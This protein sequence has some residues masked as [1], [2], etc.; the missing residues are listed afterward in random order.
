LFISSLTR[1][2]AE[3]FYKPLSVPLLK[4]K[5]Q[6]TQQQQKGQQQQQRLKLQ[7]NLPASLLIKSHLLL[8]LNAKDQPLCSEFAL[9][10]IFSL[11]LPHTLKRTKTRA[12]LRLFLASHLTSRLLSHQKLTRLPRGPQPKKKLPRKSEGE[13]RL[14]AL[15]AQLALS[16]SLLLQMSCSLALGICTMCRRPPLKLRVRPRALALR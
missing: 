1:K 16:L 8:F 10:E 6:K 14:T 4:Q 3:R 15:I 9:A 13:L 2:K 5:L 7:L 12:S 11:P